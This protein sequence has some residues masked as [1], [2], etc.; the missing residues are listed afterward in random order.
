M[1]SDITINTRSIFNCLSTWFRC[2]LFC[3]V[4]FVTFNAFSEQ[5]TNTKQAPLKIA[6]P[7]RISINAAPG[8]EFQ[9]LVNFLKEYWQIWAI[10]NHREISFSYMPTIKAYES[11]ANNSIDIVAVTHHQ[12]NH[13][14]LL[15]SIPYAKWKQ[16]VF[17][18]IKRNK[19]NGI[20][21][22]IYSEDRSA[23]DF[24]GQHIE[25][26]YYQDIDKLLA[27]YEKFDALYATKPWLLKE[28]LNEY[29][30]SGNFHVNKNEAPEIFFR[31]AINKK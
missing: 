9:L 15:F 3:S 30:M 17:R 5:R 25:R 2:T 1:D 12:N 19:S 4:L 7:D 27:D 26:Y 29:K 21:I 22:G 31:F 6:L 13:S 23:L 8:E 18:R 14:N 11:L 16:S 24:L 20:Q 28:K 10:D